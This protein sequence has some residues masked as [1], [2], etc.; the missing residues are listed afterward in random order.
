MQTHNHLT[1]LESRLAEFEA[2]A[3][4]AIFSNWRKFWLAQVEAIRE[5][6]K[7][8]MTNPATRPKEGVQDDQ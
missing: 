3:A 8:K 7:A 1:Y 4:G 5:E 6:I 2:L